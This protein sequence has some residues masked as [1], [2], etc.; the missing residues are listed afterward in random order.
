MRRMIWLCA[1]VIAASGRGA[2]ADDDHDASARDALREAAGQDEL[3]CARALAPITWSLSALSDDLRDEVKASFARCLAA[4]ERH[5]KQIKSGGCRLKIAGAISATAAPRAMVPRGAKAACVAL[6]PGKPDVEV[7][8]PDYDT[9]AGCPRAELVWSSGKRQHRVLA[10]AGGPLADP[11]WCCRLDSVAAGN[12]DGQTVVRIS[13][14][15]HPC[16]GGTAYEATD[17]LYSWNGTALD[18]PIDLSIDYH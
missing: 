6:F 1:A 8:S 18:S 13:G 15:G 17:A 4:A 3:G 5:Y 14:D 7:T 9:G 16:G 2:F 10:F 11:V 12:L